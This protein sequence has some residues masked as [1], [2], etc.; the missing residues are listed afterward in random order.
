VVVRA[1]PGAP[2][3]MGWPGAAAAG[4]SG[5]PVAETGGSGAHRCCPRAPP[6][7]RGEVEPLLAVGI[8]ATPPTMTRRPAET[9]RWSRCS[10]V[11]SEGGE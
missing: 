2:V 10:P 5:E 1:R 11:G 6:V 7:G 8:R 3:V 4:R 9:T